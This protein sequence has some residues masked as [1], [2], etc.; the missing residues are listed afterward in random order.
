LVEVVALGAVTSASASAALPEIRPYVANEAITGTG[1][2]VDFESASHAV[3]VC[4]SSSFAGTMVGPKELVKVVLTMNCAGDTPFCLQGNE[5]KWA[6]H[7]LKGR[8]GY[9]S[10]TSKTVG[11][12]LEP[13][14]AG[15]PIATCENPV[16][17][18]IEIRG[19]VI[20]AFPSR[21]PFK[22]VAL[23]YE[24]A[25]G[26]QALTHFEGEEALHELDR[27]NGYEGVFSMN[28]TMNLKFKEAKEI[29]A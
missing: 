16:G 2:I 27:K 21:G 28:T 8:L 4:N 9:I 14:A 22:E 24:G 17:L 23:K 3:Y 29:Q 1:G 25:N 15:G 10:K 26:K 5:G 7:E 11:L 6:S 20:A 19:S 13:A 18:T 12:L